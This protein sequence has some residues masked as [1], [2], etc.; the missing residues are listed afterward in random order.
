MYKYPLSGSGDFNAK[1]S[2]CGKARLMS[3]LYRAMGLGF[4][5][6]G[7]YSDRSQGDQLLVNVQALDVSYALSFKGHKSNGR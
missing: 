5:V 1:S 2:Q 4:G 6:F 7:V 3:W